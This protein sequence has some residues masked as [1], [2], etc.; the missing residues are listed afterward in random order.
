MGNWN[1]TNGVINQFKVLDLVTLTGSSSVIGRAITLH[2]ATDDCVNVP[3]SA[4]RLALCVIGVAKPAVTGWTNTA[5]NGNSGVTRAVC[6]LQQIGTSGVSGKVLLSTTGSATQVTAM[7]N[8]ISGKHGFHIHE[9]G[10][11]SAADGSSA[12]NHFDPLATGNHSIPG[13]TP[14]HHVGD[15]GNLFHYN[16][17][18]TAYYSYTFNS[19][20]TLI[21]ANN[22][23]GHAIVVHSAPDNCSQPSGAAGSRVAWCVIG[24][25]NSTAYASA[26]IIPAD[27]TVVSSQDF[28]QCLAADDDSSDSG[29][30]FLTGNTTLMVLLL[31]LV[32][33]FMN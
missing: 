8:G 7:V 29:V 24:V 30:A 13:A 4:S 32:A 26:T 3:S 23:I 2:A 5:A 1:V 9:F 33:L 20:I 18:S 16:G 6:N 25:A 10:D 14:N 27:Q 11:L 12:G 19:L 31:A 17:T 28:S 22:V 21:G 15:M